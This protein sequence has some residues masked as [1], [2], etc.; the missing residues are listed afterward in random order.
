MME[1]QTVHN[2][3]SEAEPVS[4]KAADEKA[5]AAPGEATLDDLLEPP[6]GPQASDF[7]ESA[8]LGRRGQAARSGWRHLLVELTGGRLRPPP[9]L[10]ELR[11]NQ[12]MNRVRT[13]FDGTRRI[14]VM[15]RKGGVGKTTV[16]VG[17]GA[18]FASARGDRVVAVDANP[19]AGN[20]A[21]RIAG[22]CQRTITDL[23][24]DSGRIRSFAHM[25]GYTSQ[26]VES[27]LEVL[28]SDDDARIAQALDRDAYRQVVALLDHFY[29]LI[30]LDTGTGILDSANQG[31][32]TEADQLVLVV[33]P[34]LDG[35]K[36]G[37]QTLDWL[38]EHGHTDLV[39]SAVVVIN[40]IE[41][42]SDPI[43]Q[44]ARKH[45]EARCRQVVSVPWDKTLEGGGRTTLSGLH[46]K[47]RRAF[48]DVAAALADG[49][50]EDP[51]ARES[52][53]SAS[54]G[55]TFGPLDAW[56]TD[57]SGGSVRD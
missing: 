8:V 33:R 50:G 56:P 28:A 52:R 35:A 4:G 41:R 25:R 39:A 9:G 23:L 37:A 29:N 12:L 46:R 1:P 16:T 43:V 44:F 30:L 51:L 38:E 54:H 27:R 40:G 15:S 11:R 42:E 32:I 3:P 53:E 31:L 19:D 26:C 6:L 22:D 49:F 21:H 20:L 13:P 14:V 57:S 18:T 55:F 47:T 45:F 2:E 5:G 24:A 34:A 36:A 7:S 10:G 48:L 17:V